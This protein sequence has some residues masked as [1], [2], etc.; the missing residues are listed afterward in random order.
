MDYCCSGLTALTYDVQPIV[1]GGALVRTIDDRWLPY[2]DP[3]LVD[4]D[5]VLHCGSRPRSS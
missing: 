4:V 3:L 1:V 2:L 5:Y